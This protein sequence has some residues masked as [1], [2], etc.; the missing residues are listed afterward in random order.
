MEQWERE[1]GEMAYAKEDNAIV[2][3]TTDKRYYAKVTEEVYNSLTSAQQSECILKGIGAGRAYWRPMTPDTVGNMASLWFKVHLTQEALDH[4]NIGWVMNLDGTTTKNGK[5]VNKWRIDKNGADGVG[6]YRKGI[7]NNHNTY[8]WNYTSGTPDADGRD[9]IE[10]WA[11]WI[12]NE[13]KVDWYKENINARG[14]LKGGKMNKKDKKLDGLGPV[15]IAP[16]YA[17]GSITGWIRIDCVQASPDFSPDEV[18][19]KPLK[20]AGMDNPRFG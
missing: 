9:S 14:F 5:T 3:K 17:L 10:R 19:E 20:D 1:N 2:Y 15:L 6:G 4:F 18:Y 16:P 13:T 8:N 7:W 11:K 12:K